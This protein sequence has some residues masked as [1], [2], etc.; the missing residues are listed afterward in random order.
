MI[1][2]EIGHKILMRIWVCKFQH[3]IDW[4]SAWFS[5]KV[6]VL[7]RKNEKSNFFQFT[8]HNIFDS[9]IGMHNSSIAF[10]SIPDILNPFTM[11]HKQ[12][13][14]SATPRFEPLTWCWHVKVLPHGRTAPAERGVWAKKWRH[15]WVSLGE[16][17]CGFRM[18]ECNSALSFLP[19]LYMPGSKVPGVR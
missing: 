1:E 7:R 5:S 4:T 6:S 11:D 10:F 14:S 19:V 2:F 18:Q 16:S 15:C 12:L 3:I 8:V 17:L 9:E 13:K